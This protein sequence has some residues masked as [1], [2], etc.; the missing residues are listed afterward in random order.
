M[1]RNEPGER[2]LVLLPTAKDSERTV[3]ACSSLNIAYRA[4]ADLKELCAEI[5]KGAGAALLNEEVILRDKSGCLQE[6]L[7]SEPP[8]SDF[9]LIVLVP[10]NRKHVWWP[11]NS[12][13]LN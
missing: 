4:C 11:E 12:L 3:T 8:W 10:E 6:T 7:R 5:L 9:P 2:L 13:N 1:K